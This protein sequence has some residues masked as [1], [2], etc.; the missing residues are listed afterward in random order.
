MSEA[1][2]LLVS[3]VL[4][5]GNAFFVGAEFA[6]ITA[7]R[8]RLT[9]LAEDGS[10][11][12]RATLRAGEQLPLL[13]AGAQL[14]ITLCSLGLG[15]L[16]EP[17]LA[18]LLE[19]PFEAL[20]APA[21]IL[22]PVAFTLALGLVAM[23]H[24]VLGEMVPKNL[25]IAGPERVA[26]ILVPAHYAFCR[27]ARPLLMLFTMAATVVLKLFHVTPRDELDSA[28]TGAELA[29]MISDSRREG[30]LDDHESSRLTQTLGSAGR[31]VADV[32]VPLERVVTLPVAA[33]VGDVASAVAEFGV[34]RF[35][36]REDSGRLIGYLHVKDVLEEADDPGAVLPASRVRGL[37]EL[38]CDARLDDALAALRRSAAHLARVVTTRGGETVGVV[39]MDD[40]LQYYMGAVRAPAESTVD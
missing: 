39:S 29:E 40:L 37:P 35:P 21:A 14:G 16:A 2:G 26:V 34:S 36:V 10:L 13:I 4:L 8:D 30:L 15:L 38:P 3:V 18:G 28:Y 1:A 12:A 7:R 19:R 17:A 25:A 31:T 33:T 23:L 24:T 20:G 11:S 5:A 27:V 32:M 22:H 9:A 6:I